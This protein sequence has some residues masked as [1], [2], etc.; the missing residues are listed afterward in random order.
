MNFQL[1]DNG[2]KKRD[3]Y[4]NVC[5][6]LGIIGFIMIGASGAS[7]SSGEYTYDNGWDW[8]YTCDDGQIIMGEGGK[9]ITGIEND[10]YEDCNDG[11]D[12]VS[13]G[14]ADTCGG[15]LCCGSIIFAI[16]ALSTKVN[17][18]QVVVIQQQPQYVPVVQQ[19]VQQPVR[20]VAPAPQVTPKPTG[21]DDTPKQVWASKAK[22]LELA[23]NWEEAA[24]A[25]EK[26][27]M[28]ADAG[29]VRQEN[30]KQSQPMVQIGQ[31]GNT[32]LNDSVMIADG[33]QKTCNNCGNNVEAT[34]NI[35]PHCSSQL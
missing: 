14:F 29:R 28:Y 25:Y 12:E 35:C 34:W 5:I 15:L 20:Q 24:N 11:S 2:K 33:G 4:W 19:V 18:Q 6:V 16:S 3:R 10:G 21:W 30:L 22:N 26:A 1:P 7:S 32:V 9:Q 13:D 17:Q 8:E 27:G 31:V 23:R